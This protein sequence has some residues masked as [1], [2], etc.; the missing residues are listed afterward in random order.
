MTSTISSSQDSLNLIYLVL[1]LSADISST[2]LSN[3]SLSLQPYSVH[4]CLKSSW[5]LLLTLRKINLTELTSHIGGYCKQ[6]GRVIFVFPLRD[7]IFVS[8]Q[9]VVSLPR[10][11]VLKGH[12][13]SSNHPFTLLLPKYFPWRYPLRYLI[14]RHTACAVGTM[15]M[16]L[17]RLLESSY[18]L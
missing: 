11:E 8:L 4:D 9:E 1:E 3:L 6:A 17:P 5:A 2:I 18:I 10:L 7:L 14:S 15:T 13:T 12:Q 16:L